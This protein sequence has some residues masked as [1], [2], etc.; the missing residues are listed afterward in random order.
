MSTKH[1]LDREGAVVC[2]ASFRDDGSNVTSNPNE[3][4]CPDCHAE[5]RWF[6]NEC[7]DVYDYYVTRQ[8]ADFPGNFHVAYKTQ[9]EAELAAAHLDDPDPAGGAPVPQMAYDEAISYAIF[10]INTITDPSASSDADIARLDLH[11]EE[12]LASLVDLRETVRGLMMADR[13]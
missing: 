2:T 5:V 9:D 13:S 12:V 11:A 10:A 1:G 8:E 3:V 4:T 6:I 7:G